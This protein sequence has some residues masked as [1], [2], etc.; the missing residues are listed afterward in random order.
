MKIENQVT[1][2]ELSKQLKECGYKQEGMWWW[3]QIEENKNSYSLELYTLGE[4][5]GIK[6]CR[7]VA[8]TVAELGL[9]LLNRCYTRHTK[10]GWVCYFQGLKYARTDEYKCDALVEADAR[11]KM[12][13]HL[14]KE[15]VI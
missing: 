10:R 12:W 8:P 6:D 14:K 11:A 7:F 2:R 13:L 15:K 1:C 5:W 9:A 3:E 4:K